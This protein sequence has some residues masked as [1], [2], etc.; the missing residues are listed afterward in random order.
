VIDGELTLRL[1][2]ELLE[3]RAGACALAPKGVPHT[4]RVDSD[5]ARWLVVTT[6][7]DFEA[8]VRAAPREPEHDGLP[9]RNGAPAP[10]QQEALA[11]LAAAHEIELVG[12][13]LA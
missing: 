3:L 8:F 12:P 7:G 9:Q 1:G 5:T 2:D 6:N 10:E 13:P 4:Y 11:A